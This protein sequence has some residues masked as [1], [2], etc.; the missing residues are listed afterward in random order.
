MYQPKLLM[1]LTSSLILVALIMVLINLDQG[2]AESFESNKIK[3][4]NQGLAQL[5]PPLITQIKN[6]HN[7]GCS[8][9]SCL[10]GQLINQ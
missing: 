2:Q 4:L 7:L 9:P 1:T 6:Q 3:R 5:N 10:R 8:C